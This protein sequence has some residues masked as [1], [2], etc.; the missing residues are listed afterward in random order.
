M[1]ARDF[2]RPIERIRCNEFVLKEAA[3]SYCRVL[4]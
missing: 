2:M 1:L 3:F 4:V